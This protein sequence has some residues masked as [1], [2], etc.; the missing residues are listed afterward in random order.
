MIDTEGFDTEVLRMADLEKMLPKV[1]RFEAKHSPRRALRETIQ[2]LKKLDY[3]ISYSDGD[4][5]AIAS[6]LRIGPVKYLT[7]R[8]RQEDF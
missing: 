1:I 4:C 2:R 5:T 7:K 3:R 6:D 8:W